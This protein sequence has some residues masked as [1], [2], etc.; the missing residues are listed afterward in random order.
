MDLAEYVRIYAA[1]YGKGPVEA[2]AA[3]ASFGKPPQWFDETRRAVDAAAQR[4]PRVAAEVNARVTLHNAA[5]A[6]RSLPPPAPARHV[7][8]RRCPRCGGY[9][10]TAPRTA[11]VYCDYCGQFFDYDEDLAR[12][13]IGGAELDT[14]LVVLAEGVSQEVARARAAGDDD[15]YRRAWRWPYEMDMTLC[16]WNWSPRIGDPA[17]RAAMVDYCAGVTFVNNHDPGRRALVDR[18]SDVGFAAREQPTEAGLEAYLHA[19]YEVIAHEVESYRRAGLLAAHP[20]RFDPATL[21]HVAFTLNVLDWHGKVPDAVFDWLIRRAGVRT[22]K[23]EVDA[24]GIGQATCGSCGG[25]LLLVQGASVVVC[26]AC[27]HELDSRHV[28]PCPGCG[29]HLVARPGTQSAKCAWCTAV[30]SFMA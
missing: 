27:G 23:A 8:A 9:K 18:R 28:Y 20:D 11:Y 15:A 30:V 29:A 14:L 13:R 7:R 3:L 16:P 2:A 4:D 12:A 21:L 26:E 10:R 19:E 25:R 1:V 24:V 6:A 5:L 22:E 17:Y